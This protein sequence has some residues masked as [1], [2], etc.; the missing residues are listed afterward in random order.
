MG[1]VYR[2]RDTRSGREVAVKVLRG[3]GVT[4]DQRARFQREAEL[5]ARVDHPGVVRV[6]RAGF[7]GETPFI[8]YELVEGARALETAAEGLDLRQRCGLIVEVA[9]AL[10]AA[11][12]LGIVHRDLKPENVVVDARGRARVLDFGVAKGLDLERLTRTGTL[13][14]TPHFM[15][16]EQITGTGEITPATDVWALGVLLHESLTGALPFDG[17]TLAELMTRILGGAPASPSSLSPDAPRRLDAVVLR[18]LS[19][20]PGRRYADGAAFAQALEEALAAPEPASRRGLGQGLAIAG[21]L[22]VA[23]V[24]LLLAFGSTGAG[25]ER[26]APMGAGG[27][28]LAEAAGVRLTVKPPPPH[29]AGLNP[30]VLTALVEGS[31]DVVDVACGDATARVR[32]DAAGRGSVGLEVIAR[33]GPNTFTVVAV[34]PGGRR[35]EAR[36]QF[37]FDPWPAWF[38]SLPEGQRAPLPLPD[39]LRFGRKAGDYLN[40]ADGSAL[41]WVPPGALENVPRRGRREVAEGTFVGRAEV[42]WGAYLRYCRETGAPAPERDPAAPSGELDPVYNVSWADAVAYCRW[43]GLRLLTEAEWEFAVLSTADGRLAQASGV[44]GGLLGVRE[45][46]QDRPERAAGAE[47]VRVIRGGSWQNLGMATYRDERDEGFLDLDLGFR[48]AR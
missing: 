17:A 26:A 42:S 45:W 36:V 1:V 27:S 48:V 20:E 2:A 34:D 43:A 28:A 12:A 19:V 21:G 35:A 11:H 13:V 41:V 30:L 33:R 40:E 15:A 29:E 10:G 24:G 38:L 39:G 23:G 4:P 22:V 6:H 25:Q 7:E 9:R 44:E 47:Y 37:D 46:C 14:G 5:T 32:L 31:G 3:N 18:A 16:P 8:V